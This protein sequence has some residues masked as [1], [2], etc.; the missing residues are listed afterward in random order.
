MTEDLAPIVSAACPSGAIVSQGDEQLH[1]AE[2]RSDFGVD[3]NGVTVGILSDSFDRAEEVATHAA[4]DVSSGDLPGTGNPCGFTAPVDVLEDFSS[5]ATDEGR[6]MA[7]IVHDLAPGASLDFATA[8]PTEFAFAENI[9]ALARAGAKVIVDDVSFLEE[10]FFQEGPAADAVG[11]VTAD[12]V[13]YFTA[14]GNNNL[15]DSKGDEIASWEAPQFRDAESC[16]SE[17]EA[18]AGPGTDHCMNFSPEKGGIPDPTFGIKVADGATLK[19]DLQW[20]EPWFGV[21][22]DLD[23][24]LLNAEGQPIEEEHRL[25][26]STEDNVKTGQPFEFFQWENKTGSP[27]EVQLAI[28]HCAEACNPIASKTSKPRLKLALMENGSG[29]TETEYPT[30]TGGDT[31]GPTIFGHNGAASAISVGAV[32]Y[33]RGESPERYSSRGPVTH[34]FGP[35]ESRSA[36]APALTSPQTI[37]KPDVVASDCV[38]TTFFAEEEG[39]AWRFCGTSAAAPHAAA[40]A[41]LM[42]QSNPSLSP[43]GIR[44]ALTSTAQ[45]V[46]AFGPEAVGAGLVD[47]RSAVAA[48]ALPPTV[49]ITSPPRRVSRNR[50]PSI[51]FSANRPASFACSIDGGAPQPCTSPFTPPSPLAD[52]RHAFAVSAA[53]FAGRVGTSETVIFDV[54]TSRPRTFFRRRPPRLIVARKGTGGFQVWLE[55]EEGQV[56]VQGRPGIAPP[57]ST[58]AL[59]VVRCG[60]APCAGK[61][62]RCGRQC[63]PHAGGL[64]L[65]GQADRL[66]AVRLPPTVPLA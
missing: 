29:V 59:A 19:V 40:V 53:D 18:I 46:G 52:G 23:A 47:A 63:R 13:A 32:P 36:P 17:L 49:S 57:L 54:D 58:E 55:R 24:F 50:R 1:A 64:A 6:A 44:S 16:P 20:A 31:V 35:V 45:P 42:L 65:Q 14:A 12:G 25:V 56:H 48:V 7:Q 39:S 60:Q 21:E 10:P 38:A 34:Y 22:T 2:A 37:S 5:Q 26:G 51:G 9:R 66:I 8:F 62:S 28:N 3:G 61:G 30:S 33:D 11:E 4:E 27:Q 43:A 15:I 41:A